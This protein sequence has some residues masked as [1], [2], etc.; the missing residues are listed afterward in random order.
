VPSEGFFTT[1]AQVL[2]TLLIA[3]VVEAG[4]IQSASNT[5]YAE[6]LRHFRD[7]D[8]RMRGR[9]VMYDLLPARAVAMEKRIYRGQAYVLPVFA[10]V[11]IIGEAA[12]LV[13]VMAGVANLGRGL[14]VL[15]EVVCS[16]CVL[17]GIVVIVYL[18][19]LKISQSREIELMRLELEEDADQEA[20]PSA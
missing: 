20:G 19:A 15:L 4:L 1:V 3:F 14:A 5:A 16:V 17:S 9:P 8:P 7:R 6:L 13:P 11:M 10:G 12:S 18:A 2:P